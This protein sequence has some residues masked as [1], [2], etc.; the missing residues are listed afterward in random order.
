[1]TIVSI[2]SARSY[3]QRD[4]AIVLQYGIRHWKMVSGCW[5]GG[6]GCDDGHILGCVDRRHGWCGSEVTY[7]SQGYWIHPFTDHTMFVCPWGRERVVWTLKPNYIT[8]N[9]YVHM[10]STTGH[11]KRYSK[12]NQI[13]WEVER[14][15]SVQ[16]KCWLFY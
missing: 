3:W 14:K 11:F 16:F 13:L 6:T 7:L 12:S 1:M 15:I 9:W 4:D 8:W 5:I 10:T 2:D